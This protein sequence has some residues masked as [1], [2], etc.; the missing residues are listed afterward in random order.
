MKNQKK[1]ILVDNKS[2]IFMDYQKLADEYLPTEQITALKYKMALV[3]RDF[4][5]YKMWKYEQH[6]DLDNSCIAHGERV[7]LNLTFLVAM[8][9]VEA[10]IHIKLTT[11]PLDF[12]DPELRRGVSESLAYKDLMSVD[13]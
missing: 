3:L 11:N 2:I 7:C 1:E 6:Q 10:D 13:L 4:L 8:K 9:Q 5:K 12:I